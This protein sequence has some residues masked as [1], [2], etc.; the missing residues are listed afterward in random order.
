[1]MKDESYDV[2]APISEDQN[3]LAMGISIDKCHQRERDRAAYPT[4]LLMMLV[5]AM[6]L[7]E[8]FAEGDKFFVL[9]NYGE[10]EFTTEYTEKSNDNLR[11]LEDELVEAER[12]RDLAAQYRERAGVDFIP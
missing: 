9:I 11:K 1:M 7:F 10:L 5:R 8:V 12:L 3:R 2:N 6:K 4:R